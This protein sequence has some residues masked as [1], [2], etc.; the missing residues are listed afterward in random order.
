[1]IYKVRNNEIHESNRNN[2]IDFIRNNYYIGLD[3]ETTGFDPHTNKLLLIQFGNRDIQF[4]VDCKTED[5]S[6]LEPF[7]NNNNSNLFL[8]HNAKFDVQFL[9]KY[10]WYPK[11]I[12]DTFLAECI[13]TTGYEK[14]EK[15]LGLKGV[16]LKYCNV[17]I[18]KSIRGAIHRTALN[19]DIIK[20]AAKDTAY[21]ED[22]MI[23][24]VAQLKELD[25]IR[26]AQLEFDTVKVLARMEYDGILIDKEKWLGISK[27]TEAEVKE[28]ENRLDDLIIQSNNPKL[29]KL[30]N[31][32]T[33]LFGYEENKTIINWASASQKKDILNHLGYKVSDVSDK[34]LQSIKANNPI[35]QDLINLSKMNKLATSF[36]KKFLHFVNPVTG[37]VHGNHWQILSTGRLSMSEPNL[38][39]I[40]AHG[41]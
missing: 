23:A 20:Y 17:E 36:G 30:I 15:E 24:Q 32:Q 40:P 12:Y 28:I 1:M 29:K 26:V 18:D 3:T 33:N 8:F 39:Q 14:E 38:Q 22:I 34:T 10:N 31:N 21:L 27:V 37:R 4:V 6:F 16:G 41:K 9:M 7:V 5:I 25:L 13:L 2:L 19:D 11:R 35:I